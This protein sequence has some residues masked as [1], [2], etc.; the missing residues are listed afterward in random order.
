MQKA[1]RIVLGERGQIEEPGDIVDVEQ[2]HLVG[3][4]RQAH[5][6]HGDA[7]EEWIALPWLEWHGSQQVV[8]A[9]HD[10]RHMVACNSDCIADADNGRSVDTQLSEELPEVVAQISVATNTQSLQWRDL[11]RG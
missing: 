4:S 5:R 1:A 6:D 3:P 9:E 11:E 2:V 10:V 7:R 8:L